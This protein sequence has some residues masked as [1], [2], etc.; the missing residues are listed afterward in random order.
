VR[1]VLQ[2]A[3]FA[4]LTLF[5]FW[6]GE[7]VMG[8]VAGGRTMAFI[9]LA[10]TQIVHSFNMRSNHSLFRI[11]PFSNGK[12][13]LAALVSVI[14]IALVVFIPPIANVFGLIVLPQHMYLKAAGLAFI[15]LPV[16]E[17]TKLLGIIRQRHH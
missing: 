7:K 4:A 1:V 8:D 16:L 14:L 6:Y 3:M 11:G 2:G 10:L 9:I 17:V 13:N 15:P 5:G 12:L